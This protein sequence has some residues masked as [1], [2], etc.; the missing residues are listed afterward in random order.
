MTKEPMRSGPLFAL[1]LKRLLFLA[2]TIWSLLSSSGCPQLQWF[3]QVGQYYIEP[4]LKL[5]NTIEAAAIHGLD[6]ITCVNMVSQGRSLSTAECMG[7]STLGPGRTVVLSDTMPLTGPW[8]HGL[9][10][11][12]DSTIGH[13][14]LHKV[15]GS[16]YP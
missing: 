1:T 7:Q 16:R 8:W 4:D 2:C 11:P 14:A 5:P 9:L 3:L 13:K 10:P 12:I 6:P 15:I